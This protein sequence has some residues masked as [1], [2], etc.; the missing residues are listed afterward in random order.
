M[1]RRVERRDHEQAT[2]KLA[3]D[4]AFEDRP[5]PPLTTRSAST[6]TGGQ[7]LSSSTTQLDPELPQGGEQV[8]DGPLPHSRDAVEPVTAIAELQHSAV[9]NRIVVPELATKISALCG[10]N[11]SILPWACMTELVGQSAWT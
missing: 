3:A 9:R 5:V 2:N 6:M 4:V 10:R 7:P 1:A 8:F 11:Q